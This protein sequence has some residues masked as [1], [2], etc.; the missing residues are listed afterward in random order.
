[1]SWQQPNGIDSRNRHTSV[2]RQ[3]QRAR[4]IPSLESLEDRTCPT[5]VTPRPAGIGVFSSGTWILRLTATAG[6]ANAGAFS[7]GYNGAT[8]VSGDWTGTGTDG[9]GVFDNGN[10]A[11]RNTADAG[12]G[13]PDLT[14]QYG[15]AG[16]IPVLEK[17]LSRA[18]RD[19]LADSNEAASFLL[20]SRLR[21]WSGAKA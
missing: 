10:W 1:M 21:D 17:A 3:K 14:F 5:T 6:D 4:F 13:T 19:Y 12:T 7:F 20:M 16:A 2:R 8:P 15:W 18:P 9:I 11:L